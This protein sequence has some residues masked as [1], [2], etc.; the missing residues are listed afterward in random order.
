MAGVRPMQRKLSK[1]KLIIGDKS[2]VRDAPTRESADARERNA[3][4]GTCGAIGNEQ[5]GPA[6]QARC[7]KRGIGITK[8]RI[9]TSFASRRVCAISKR[10]LANPRRQAADTG[11]VVCLDMARLLR[12]GLQMRWSESPREEAKVCT[13][14]HSVVN[15]DTADSYSPVTSLPYRL[16]RT[17]VGILVH[18][19]PQNAF[20]AQRSVRWPCRPCVA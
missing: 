7:T 11:A 2:C 12:V 18:R 10:K 6:C 14:R 5:V 13:F 17:H 1:S 8:R 19:S 20:G 4:C 3:A 9:G 16:R 15:D